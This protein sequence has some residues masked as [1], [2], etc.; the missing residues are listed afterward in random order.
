MNLTN[1]TNPKQQIKKDFQKLKSNRQFLTILILLFVSVFFWI[2]I[3]LITSQS[4]EEISKELTD[5]AKP[6][7]PN[8]DKDILAK[9]EKKQSYSK[10]ELASFTIYKILTTRDGRT[11]KVVPLEITIEDIDPKPEV[12]PE[13]KKAINSLIQ[14]EAEDT[15]LNESSSSS[16]NNS[17][18]DTN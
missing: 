13:A 4:K 12:K 18:I 10:N 14:T 17:Q 15:N 11:E 8:I 16:Q 7:V 5:L 1:N 6:L 3:S 2:T 9:L